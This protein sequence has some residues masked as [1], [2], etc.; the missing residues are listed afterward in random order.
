MGIRWW[1]PLAVVFFLSTPAAGGGNFV[2]RDD[3]TPA[4]YAPW[5]GGAPLSADCFYMST[6]SRTWFGASG[7]GCE[8]PRAFICEEER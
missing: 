6:G 8:N 7:M 5:S 1:L 3:G 4:L 2:W